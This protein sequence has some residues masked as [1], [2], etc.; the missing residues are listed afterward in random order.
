MLRNPGSDDPPNDNA[1]RGDQNRSFHRGPAAA[2]VTAIT[3]HPTHKNSTRQ[4]KK[5]RPDTGPFPH[6]GGWLLWYGDRTRLNDS[7]AGIDERL[8]GPLGGTSTQNG[9]ARAL[10][11]N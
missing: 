1:D 7:W 9:P 5:C 2:S 3:A 8:K 11:G 4:P 10:G 6:V